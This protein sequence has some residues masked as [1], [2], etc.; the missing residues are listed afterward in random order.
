MDLLRL[1][2]SFDLFKDSSGLIC[3]FLLGLILSKVQ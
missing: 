1:L 3:L 2:L